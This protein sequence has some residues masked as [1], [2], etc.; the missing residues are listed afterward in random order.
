MGRFPESR[1]PGVTRFMDFVIVDSPSVIIRRHH[2]TARFQRFTDLIGA[3]A[4][5]ENDTLPCFFIYLRFEK[6]KK[7]KKINKRESINFK[8]AKKN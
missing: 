3:V 4:T 1:I 2:E 8:K 6:K 5:R 7:K